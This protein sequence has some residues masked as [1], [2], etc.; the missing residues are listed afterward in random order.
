M[1][2]NPAM[3]LATR[4]GGQ[5]GSGTLFGMSMWGILASLLFSS[6]GYYYLKRGRDQSDTT[7][8]GCG[9]ALLVYS[10]FVTN[11]L[12]IVLIGAGLMAVPSI[13]ERF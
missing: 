12:Y 3:A 13:M 2:D 11:T 10:F 6:I 1:E 4:M 7:K 5:G 8:I 9:I